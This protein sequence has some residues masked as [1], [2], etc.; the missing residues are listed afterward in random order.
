M[1]IRWLL[2]MHRAHCSRKQLLDYLI[3]QAEKE[4]CVED[5]DELIETLVFA[6]RPLDEPGYAGH[7]SSRT[8]YVALNL[9]AEREKIQKDYERSLRQW[10]KERTTLDFYILLY[11]SILGALTEEE[12]ALLVLYYQDGYSMEMISQIPLTEHSPG[13]RSKSTL[14]RMMQKIIRKGQEIAGLQIG[15]I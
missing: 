6:R 1:D 4:E 13:P 3:E 12:R 11:D 7:Q 8:E 5:K 9:D 2:K 14:R 10:K 15:K